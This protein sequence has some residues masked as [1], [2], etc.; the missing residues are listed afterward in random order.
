FALEAE[1]HVTAVEYRALEP[2]RLHM[3]HPRRPV[4][5][6]ARAPDS[7][8]GAV[9]VSTLR[10]VIDPRRIGA[11][12]VGVAI[13]HGI[14]TGAR[15]VHGQRG[16]PGAM[17]HRALALAVLL[18]TV[19]AAPVHDDRRPG[20]AAGNLQI[21]NELLAIER[22]LDDLQRRIEMLRRLAEIAHRMPVGL[23]L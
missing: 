4:A 12:G 7:D 5:A 21:A 15:H 17:G 3:R 11:L 6:E 10:Q 2:L 23:D 22:D 8:A 1:M 13:E 20:D 9:H 18:P 16:E 19:D 14:L